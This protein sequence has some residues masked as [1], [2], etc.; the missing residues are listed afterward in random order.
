MT[1]HLSKFF[2][3]INKIYVDLYIVVKIYIEI[4]L[5]NIKNFF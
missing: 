1:Y 3:K 2:I 5:I 4:Y